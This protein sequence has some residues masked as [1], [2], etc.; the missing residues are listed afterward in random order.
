MGQEVNEMGA[1]SR[2]HGTQGS[3]IQGLLSW[4]CG[5]HD[6]QRID[7]HPSVA[8]TTMLR[9]SSAALVLVLLTVSLPLAVACGSSDADAPSPDGGASTTGAADADVPATAEPEDGTEPEDRE[10]PEPTKEKPEAGAP[11]GFPGTYASPSIVREGSLYHAYFPRQKIG[12]KLY[13]TPYAT[14]TEDGNWTFKGEALPKLG[15]QATGVVWAPGAAKIK[16]GVWVLYYTS[17]LAGTTAKKCIFRAHA[18]V[19]GGPFVDDHQSG[20]IWCQ[21]A[22]QWTIDAYLVQDAA[23]NWHLSARVDEP[24]GINTIKIRALDP[25]GLIFAPGSSWS[26]LTMNAPNSWEQPVLENAGVVRLKPPNGP[27]H[28]FVFYSGRSYRDDSYA[29]G[30]AD[31][32]TSID[33]PCVKKTPNGPWL[34]TTPADGLFGPG[35][36]TFYTNVAGEMM[37]S[38]E[39]LPHAGTKY[40]AANSGGYWMRTYKIT[41]DN[42][43]VPHVSLV[44]IDK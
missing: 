28:S 38:V 40:D 17:V 42:A 36:P 14:F 13:N 34:A 19:P 20:P 35:T 29:I 37:M 44:R 15:Q 12:G 33:G 2:R 1:P 16:D 11:V 25:S 39:V 31:C 32:G 4:A 8:T 23:Q 43:Y 7:I 30:Y 6:G 5:L 26:T 10:E 9:R 22:S 3:C 41:V 27:A 24:G 21:P 18:T